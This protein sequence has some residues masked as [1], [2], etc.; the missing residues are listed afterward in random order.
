MVKTYLVI[1]K[2]GFTVAILGYRDISGSWHAV[3]WSV[4]G[5]GEYGPVRD[6]CENQFNG[7]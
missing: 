7:D 6:H 4:R 3:D 5:M 1:G 2:A